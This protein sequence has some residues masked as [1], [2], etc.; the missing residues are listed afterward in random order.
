MA[1]KHV[2]MSP[3]D[4]TDRGQAMRLLNR[5]F[6]KHGESSKQSVPLF[7]LD[8]LQVGH[9]L[10]GYLAASYAL[11]HPDHVAHLVLVCPAGVVSE[12]YN[13]HAHI[14]LKHP[15]YAMA[16]THLLYST[17]GTWASPSVCDAACHVSSAQPFLA[18][19]CVLRS[20]VLPAAKGA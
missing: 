18:I 15:L 14:S 7:T 10:G 9:S 12:A 13:L 11:K 6:K 2:F 4:L 3:Q 16:T 17:A 8:W 1:L 20:I 5:T 19:A